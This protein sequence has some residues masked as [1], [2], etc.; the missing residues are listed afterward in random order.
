MYTWSLWQPIISPEMVVDAGG[1][2]CFAAKWIGK[3]G[4]EFYSDH[5]DTHKIL[6]AKLW[7][8]LDE[9][10]AVLHYNG[11]SFD[12]PHIQREFLEAGLR[13]TSPF[14]QIDL[15]RTVKKQ[16]RFLSNKLA[17]VAPQLGLHGKVEH[18]GFALWKKC[19]AGDEKAWARMRRYNV[20]DVTL[21]EEAYAT[22]RPW[23]TS[24]PSHA[25]T[26]AT[27]CC[28]KCGSE[29]LER[30]GYSTT[31]TGRYPRLHCLDCGAWSR[32]TKRVDATSVV[33]V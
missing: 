22:L 12:V 4:T 17:H 6:V 13:P 2:F 14:K 33:A 18:E 8:L 27:R 10:D 29:K 9:A 15:Y 21:L 25:A 30:R 16:G 31:T 3:R 26:R 23:V 20:R 1:I 32:E 24:H 7:N 19:L 5:H 28:P 11:T